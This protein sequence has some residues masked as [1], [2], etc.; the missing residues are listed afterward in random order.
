[1]DTRVY[2]VL[3]LNFD[4]KNALRSSRM[5]LGLWRHGSTGIKM[6]SLLEYAFPFEGNGNSLI[7]CV[8]HKPQRKRQSVFYLHPRYLSRYTAHLFQASRLSWY[9]R[10]CAS[11]TL[12]G[13]TSN[14]TGKPLRMLVRY[15]N[16]M[17]QFVNPILKLKCFEQTCGLTSQR[18][19]C[20]R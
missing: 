5:F 15:Q 18:F 7:I 11:L 3:G 14:I 9:L 10:P 6:G 17:R 12:A 2:G 1:M 13:S 20:L 19:N 8:Q 4:A 16:F